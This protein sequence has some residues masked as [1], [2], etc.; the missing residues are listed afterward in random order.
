MGGLPDISKDQGAYCDET[1]YGGP[2]GLQPINRCRTIG[3][4]N[5]TMRHCEADTTA[6]HAH[7]FN[8][9]VCRRCLRHN[10]IVHGLREQTVMATN[11]L[12]VC[13]PCRRRLLT[14]FPNNVNTCACRATINQGYQTWKC[15]DCC[16]GVINGIKDL[17]TARLQRLWHTG[18]T[19]QGVVTVDIN[20]NRQRTTPAC[21]DCN[22]RN[23]STLRQ[24]LMCLVCN[25]LDIDRR[26]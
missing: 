16:V 9:D 15:N 1:W 23:T 3:T 20:P 7:R 14:Q 2:S 21:Q 17:G 5:I 24:V 4:S 26:R 19:R 25:G 10:A 18:M 11:R 22:G 6:G 13:N 8:H 12:N